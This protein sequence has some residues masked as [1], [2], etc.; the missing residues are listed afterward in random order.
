MP[1]LTITRGN[2][3]TD[4]NP[5]KVEVID[6]GGNAIN[7]TGASMAVKFEDIRGTAF[8]VDGV[9]SGNAW[10]AVASGRFHCC[11][12]TTQTTLLSESVG[13]D[14]GWFQVRVAFAGGGIEYMDRGTLEVKEPIA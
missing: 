4:E 9:T 14:H 12:G 5:I 7:L 13:V 1:E 3:Y 8:S 6:K 11:P 2:H 10:D